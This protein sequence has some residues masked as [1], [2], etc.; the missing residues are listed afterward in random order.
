MP[1]FLVDL[2]AVPDA[3]CNHCTDA[4]HKALSEDPAGDNTGL[5]DKHANPWIAEHVEDVTRQMQE[6][7]RHIQEDFSKLLL[8][9]SI[10]TLAKA[11][12]WTRWDDQKFAAVKAHLEGLKPIE[13]TLDDW[14]MAAEYV[15][16]R[17][18]PPSV[19]NT[20]AEYMTVR[21]TLLGKI[22]ACAAKLPPRLI[23][24]VRQ[25]VP[26]SFAKVPARILS[27][28][29]SGILRVSKAR[30]AL[31]IGNV[32]SAQRAR[33]QELVI[34]H[35]QAGVLGQKEGT[36]Q[37]LKTR[38]FDSFGQ[39]N[40]DMRK[41]AVTESGECVNQGFISAT[42]PGHKVKRL[43]A[44]K[45]ACPFCAS[46]NGKV[47]T[48]VPA[49]KPD[50]DGKTEV[51]EGKTNIGRSA[52]PRKR[53]GGVMVDRTEKEMWWPAAGVMHPNCRGAWQV[54]VD[55]PPQMTPGFK[56]WMDAQLAAA[57][58]GEKT[59]PFRPS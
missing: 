42:G 1:P 51:W 48:I 57:R 20:M 9:E 28:V 5:W 4:L 32:T 7:I 59:E 49:D 18:L 41:I 50:P 15:I 40:K 2:G 43:E 8:G 52:S 3:H 56:S 23:D 12:N 13:Y 16:H 44:Y 24:S 58:R 33:M 54:V 11:E 10:S 55:T 46:I 35:V 29:E 53:V 22:S 21:A 37:A 14:M 47:F 38:L 39:M 26:T 6:A 19:I 27:A 17:Y 36:N 45:G 30:A 25:L 34:E 31:H